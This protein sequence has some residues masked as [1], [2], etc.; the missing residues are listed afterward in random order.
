MEKQQTNEVNRLQMNTLDKVL[1]ENKLYGCGFNYNE[2]D[3]CYRWM[4]K[5]DRDRHYLAI[6]RSNRKEEREYLPIGGRVT[7]GEYDVKSV[8]KGDI[9]VG[10]FYDGKKK[11]TITTEYYVV[12]A[13]NKKDGLVVADGDF[14]TYLKAYNYKQQTSG[15][16]TAKHC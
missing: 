5:W 3:D 14:S 2:E 13:N 11:R 10:G 7:Y 15:N 8:K 12:L 9:L 4:G 1:T 16:A 6:C